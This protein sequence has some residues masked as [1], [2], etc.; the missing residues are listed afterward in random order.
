M[1]KIDATTAAKPPHFVVTTPPLHQTGCIPS[2][3][4][5]ILQSTAMI[6]TE[7][8]IITVSAIVNAPVETV[9]ALW[10]GP[11]HIVNWNNA[12]ADWCTPRAENDLREAGRFTY[13]M[14]ARD[15]SMGFDFTGEYTKVVPNK[16][17]SYQIADGRTVSIF[18]TEDGSTTHIKESFE[19][20]STHPE[21]M[22]RTG[23]QAILDNFKQYA[24]TQG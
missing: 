21:E 23:W 9:W 10:T 3:Y 12:S 2:G 22:Q 5:F 14:E 24:E 16:E 4:Q 1:E 7:K 8:T 19:A 6:T 11:E 20:E 15:G 13:R 18:F 17:I